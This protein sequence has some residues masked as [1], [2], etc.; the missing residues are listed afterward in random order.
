MLNI[1]RFTKQ[2]RECN[3]DSRQ[4]YKILYVS[5]FPRGVKREFLNCQLP[6]RVF[7]IADESDANR[8]ALG[9]M[10]LG[11]YRKNNQGAGCVVCGTTERK[12]ITTQWYFD[13]KEGIYLV[14]IVCDKENCRKNCIYEMQKK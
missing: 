14:W 12:K 10:F 4:A 5:R 6:P 2:F 1:E 8:R 7:R 13:M 11:E 3:D 9:E